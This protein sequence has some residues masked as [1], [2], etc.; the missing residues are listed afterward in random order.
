MMGGH[1]PSPGV[2][3]YQLLRGRCVSGSMQ[4]AGL[5]DHRFESQQPLG[6]RVEVF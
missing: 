2:Q 3:A 6:N 5:E 4:G 1:P